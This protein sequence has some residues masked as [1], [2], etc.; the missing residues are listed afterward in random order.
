MHELPVT[1]RIIDI[2]SETAREK[3]GR[4]RKIHLV[5]GEDSG[6]V[7][8]SIQMYFDVAAEGTL[9]EGARLTIEGV[10]AKLRCRSC[11]RLFDRKPFSFDCPFCD[12]QGGPSEVGKEFYLKTVELEI[13]DGEDATTGGQENAPGGEENMSGGEAEMNGDNRPSKKSGRQCEKRE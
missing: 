8:D 12:G 1:L 13:P 10:R 2:A 3:G 6:F 11:G 5:V 7:G 4:V 9:C